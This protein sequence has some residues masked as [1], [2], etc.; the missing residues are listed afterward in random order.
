[1]QL[2]VTI[3]LQKRLGLSQPPYGGIEELLFCWECHGKTLAGRPA[4]FAVNAANRFCA[5]MA[6]MQAGDWRCWQDVVM[7]GIAQAL[8]DAGFSAAQIDGYF[9]LAGAVQTTKTHGRRPVAY[10]NHLIDDAPWPAAFDDGSL[11]QHELTRWANTDLVCKAAGHLDGPPTSPV[12]MMAAD[13]ARFQT[14]G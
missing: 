11:F 2:G 8:R 10:M 14:A 12:R 4:L 6:P 5:I 7:A 1:M 9:S 3:P 13:L